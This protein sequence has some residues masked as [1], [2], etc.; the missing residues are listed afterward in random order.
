M[1]PCLPVRCWP[2]RRPCSRAK[3]VRGVVVGLNAVLLSPSI[4]GDRDYV[5]GMLWREVLGGAN[6]PGLL[7]ILVLVITGFLGSGKTTFISRLLQ[8]QDLADTAVIVN[9][10]GETDLAHTLIASSSENIL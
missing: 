3:V 7:M 5:L 1:H 6:P 2:F 9:E 4:L 10:F 8:S